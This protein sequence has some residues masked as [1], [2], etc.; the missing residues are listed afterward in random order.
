MHHF[1]HVSTSIPQSGSGTEVQTGTYGEPVLLVGR[2]GSRGEL[3]CVGGSELQ[4]VALHSSGLGHVGHQGLQSH[5]L[6]LPEVVPGHH[7][8]HKVHLA[9]K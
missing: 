4:A 5:V 2:S 6:L 7:V 8:T 9:G 3:G 1:E